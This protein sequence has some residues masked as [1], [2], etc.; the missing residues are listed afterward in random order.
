MGAFYSSKESAHFG[1][2][3]TTSAVLAKQMNMRLGVKS[4]TIQQ[5]F[6][7]AYLPVISFF[8]T[9]CYQLEPYKAGAFSSKRRLKLL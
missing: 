3:L 2:G 4:E 7:L 5:H 6:G 1:I 9:N 8:C